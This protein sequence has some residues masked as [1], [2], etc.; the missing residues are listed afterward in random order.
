MMFPI[1]GHK[2]KPKEKRLSK[3]KLPFVEVKKKL[4]VKS[5]WMIVNTS[6]KDF[7]FSPKLSKQ[8]TWCQVFMLL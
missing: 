1:E 2:L 7:N 8:S 3:V 6:D 4:E 5:W